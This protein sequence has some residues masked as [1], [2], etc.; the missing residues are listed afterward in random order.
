M[1]LQFKQVDAEQK[2]RDFIRELVG[3]ENHNKVRASLP[4]KYSPSKGIC[5]TVQ[6]DGTPTSTT[7]YTDELVRVSVHG[8]S[9]SFVRDLMSDIDM[10]MQ[11][12]HLK[13]KGVFVST[14]LGL[15]AAP[16]SLKGGYV[17]SITYRVRYMRIAIPQQK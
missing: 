17:A 11:G 15:L 1:K 13:M 4:D 2:V 9:R 5:I 10:N 16:S 3:E 7:G 12:N 8:E 6:G 14:S